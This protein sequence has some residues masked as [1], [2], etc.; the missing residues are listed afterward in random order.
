M[1]YHGSPTWTNFE[2]YSTSDNFGGRG[3]T[4]GQTDRQNHVCR[5]QKQLQIKIEIVINYPN[6]VTFY[7]CDL[8]L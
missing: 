4:H 3:R 5:T 2:M 1:T 7:I 8:D 6:F